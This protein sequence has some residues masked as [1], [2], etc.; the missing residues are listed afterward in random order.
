MAYPM[1]TGR[2]SHR[3]QRRTAIFWG[4]RPPQTFMVYR[5]RLPPKWTTHDPKAATELFARRRTG[6]VFVEFPEAIELDAFRVEH[7]SYIHSA[8]VKFGGVA[9]LLPRL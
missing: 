5:S 3:N 6:M 1:V 8:L 2:K 7:R 4:Y 9:P